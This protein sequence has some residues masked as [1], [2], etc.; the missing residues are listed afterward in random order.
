MLVYIATRGDAQGI[1]RWREIAAAVRA[2]G[3][4]ITHDWTIDIENER[5]KGVYD[6]DLTWEQ[7]AAYA[8]KDMRGVMDADVL[9]YDAP[10]KKSEGAAYELGVHHAKRDLIKRLST[11]KGMDILRALFPCASIVIGDAQCLFAARSDYRVSTIDE[12]IAKLAE[13]AAQDETGE[14]L[15]A[16]VREQR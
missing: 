6:H 16:H 5:D 1:A 10:H 11:L 12:A 4:T 14:V 15:L 2:A 8:E 9:I 13:I 7:K 3:H